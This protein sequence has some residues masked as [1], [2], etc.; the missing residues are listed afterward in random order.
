M[1][2]EQTKLSARVK[3]DLGKTMAEGKTALARVRAKASTFLSGTRAWKTR[4]FH[5]SEL[6]KG[7]T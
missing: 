3:S 5:R 2:K 6:V 7:G 4:L 1:K